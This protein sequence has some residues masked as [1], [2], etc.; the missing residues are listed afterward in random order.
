VREVRIHGRGGQGGLTAAR[1]L[2][3]AALQEGKTAQAFPEFGPERRGAPVRSYLR[4]DER[5]IQ[6]RTSV[7]AP[8]SVIVMD[9]TLLAR[10]ETLAGMKPH[11]LVIVN[12]PT[13]PNVSARVPLQIAWVDAT[14]IA[15]HLLGRPIPSTAM[16]GAWCR[17]D[18]TL[19]LKTVETAVREWFVHRSAEENV[20]AMHQAWERVQIE[21][22]PPS[23]HAPDVKGG[24]TYA[25]IEDYP[26]VA[27]ATPVR[28]GSGQTGSW[29]V[30]DPKVDQGRCVRCGR[31]VTLCPEG[32]IALVE[33]G[34]QIDL[35]YCKGCGICIEECPVDAIAFE[36]EL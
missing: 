33:S 4:V 18:A 29:R 16:L 22:Q 17:T 19:D 31:C 30:S 32:V 12:T 3:N 10:P 1:I 6:L 8:D 13:R 2:A 36:G 34:V 5:P 24:D 15:N 27:T 21:E 20:R 23:R 9:A 7:E 35:S 14:A 28:G 25:F 11:G 26:T